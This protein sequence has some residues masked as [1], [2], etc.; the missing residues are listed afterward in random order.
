L[1]GGEKRRKGEKLPRIDS[2]GGSAKNHAAS[3][4]SGKKGA[5]NEG[6]E[7]IQAPP[8]LFK[9]VLNHQR[10]YHYAFVREA[11]GPKKHKI[12]GGHFARGGNQDW[13]REMIKSQDRESGSRGGKKP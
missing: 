13:W 9:S 12:I 7:K 2:K 10:D 4:R 6:G 5:K 1:S 3:W 11:L 8:K